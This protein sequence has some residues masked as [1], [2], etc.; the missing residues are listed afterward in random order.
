M[1]NRS[2][3]ISPKGIAA[4]YDKIHMFDVDL[5]NG[6]SYRESTTFRAG[7]KPVVAKTPWGGLG[8]SV[9]YDL[10]FPYLYRALAKKGASLIAIPSSFTAVTGKAHWHVLIRARAIETGSFVFAPAQS[11]TH[12]NGRET[13][14]H[15][16]A[17]DPWGQVLLDAGPDAEGAFL[18]EVDLA[19]VA[20]ARQAVPSLKHD[21]KLENK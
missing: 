6:E 8:M 16:L 9:C 15:T 12:W 3:L 11:G 7:A 2:F 19:R 17:V 13:F 1:A 20:A 4:R 10:R 14:G 21:R 18:V 5:P